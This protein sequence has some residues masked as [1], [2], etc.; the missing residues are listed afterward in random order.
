MS[1]SE[2]LQSDEY[3]C[4]DIEIKV[5]LRVPGHINAEPLQRKLEKDIAEV[6]NLE[7]KQNGHATYETAVKGDYL[8]RFF[9]MKIPLR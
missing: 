2:Q 4:T 6:V 9:I 8:H 5:T 1:A 3:L 7:A